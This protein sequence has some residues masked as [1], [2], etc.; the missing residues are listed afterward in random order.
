MADFCLHFS[1]IDIYLTCEQPINQP[2]IM[3]VSTE[4]SFIMD[5][6]KVSAKLTRKFDC[7]LNGISS[8]EL[9]ILYYL[10]NSSDKKMRRID[11]SEK[12]GLTASGITRLLL[13][14]E[15]IGLVGRQDDER[16][17]RVRFVTLAPGGEGK[18]KDEML[19]ANEF[20]KGKFSKESKNLIGDLVNVF[21]EIDSALN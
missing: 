14:M 4:L 15:K 16:D 21:K 20:A 13:P 17:A 6:L 3:N 8:T 12:V 19:Y 9:V 5:L 7:R 1:F 2:I 18:L 11:L 10:Y